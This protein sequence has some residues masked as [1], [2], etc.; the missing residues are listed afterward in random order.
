VSQVSYIIETSA[1]KEVRPVRLGPVCTEHYYIYGLSQLVSIGTCLDVNELVA[2][3]C[4]VCSLGL[5]FI[6]SLVSIVP[7]YILVLT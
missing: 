6:F 3:I 1:I 4:K 2:C 7:L 5:G